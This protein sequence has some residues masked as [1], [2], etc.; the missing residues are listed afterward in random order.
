[1]ITKKSRKLICL[2]LICCLSIPLCGC[3]QKENLDWDMNAFLVS[4][5]GEIEN[6]FA[7][8][9][10][11]PIVCKN[12]QTTLEF[13]IQFPSEFGYE[14]VFPDNGKY[15]PQ[16]LLPARP[17]YYVWI[18]FIFNYNKS[19]YTFAYCALSTE[20]QF[21]IMNLSDDPDHFTV[22]STEPD[23]EPSQILSY[24]Q[25][26]IGYFAPKSVE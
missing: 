22:A 1:M 8:N 6:T 9:L 23:A 25:D 16:S 12:D 3:T 13:Q 14:Y 11:G 15:A 4:A 20:K 2:I 18:G 19:N 5:D 21:L 26:F 7:L 10:E 17:E 24:F